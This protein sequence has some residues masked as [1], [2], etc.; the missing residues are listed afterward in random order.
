MVH[1]IVEQSNGF[2]EVRSAPREGTTF[3]IYLPVTSAAADSVEVP[4]SGEPAKGRETILL[5]EDSRRSKAV[6]RGIATRVRI[7]GDR[8]GGRWRGADHR[9]GTKRAY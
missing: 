1:G 8:S 5:V 6:C 4:D 2:I 7:P 3:L 9:G